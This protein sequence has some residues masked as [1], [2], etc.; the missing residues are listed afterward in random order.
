[1]PFFYHLDRG[2]RVIPLVGRPVAGL[3][4]HV[5]PV[6]RQS[7]PERRI[8]DTLD[9]YSPKYQSKHTYEEVFRWF[10]SCGL[11]QLTVGELTLGIRGTKPAQVDGR[12]NSQ[13]A[14]AQAALKN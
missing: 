3:V 11:E 14:A 6:N 13:P 1:V 7:D 8:L 10:E 5:F 4:H 12:E 9:W 2:L